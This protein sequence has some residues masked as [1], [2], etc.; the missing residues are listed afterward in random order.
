MAT[1]P[2]GTNPGVVAAIR[3]GVVAVDFA[4]HPPPI[5]S[6]LRTGVDNKIILEVQAHAGARR[7]R[8]VALTPTQ[9]LARGMAVEDTGG[10]L[11]VPVGR[12]ILSR[13]FNVFG[14]VIDRQGA[15][16]EVQWRSVH[17]PPPPLADRATTSEIFETGIKL[18]DVLAP[19]ERGGKAG[20]FGGAGV[21]KT[22]LLTDCVAV[23]GLRR[24][25]GRRKRQPPS[26]DATRRSQHRRAA[27][28]S[29]RDIP[30][31]A[32]ERCRRRTVRRHLR[33]RRI[34][35]SIGWKAAA[36][37]RC[38]DCGRNLRECR[39]DASYARRGPGLRGQQDRAGDLLSPR[40][41]NRRGALR[42]RWGVE[43]KRAAGE[44]IAASVRVIAH[45]LGG[46]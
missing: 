46:G 2:D 21:G 28:R 15:L 45:G 6:V 8:G 20:L 26:G 44:G 19:L 33:L 9:G 41:Q 12:S 43:R 3:G 14:D 35:R 18:I 34:A 42:Y 27:G 38:R 4:L 7:A 36:L 11:T 25:V 40:R 30:L 23:P 39:R 24:I 17:Q 10:P 31:G 29:Q 5:Y 32:P 13:M 22:V 16:S 37:G 1:Q